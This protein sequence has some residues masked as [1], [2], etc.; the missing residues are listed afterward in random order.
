M[1]SPGGPSGL[2]DHNATTRPMSR[3]GLTDQ[4]AKAAPPV[5]RHEMTSGAVVFY[6]DQCARHAADPDSRERCKG[7]VCHSYWGDYDAASDRRSARIPSWSTVGKCDG[8]TSSSDYLMDWA[9]REYEAGRAWRDTRAE[10]GERGT[11]AHN[12]L[13]N[14]AEGLDVIPSNGYDRAT[15]AAW[16]ALGPEVVHVEEV[17]YC[18]LLGVA[19]RFDLMANIGGA[20]CLA[21]LKTSKHIKPSFAVQLNG[22]A[23]TARRAGFPDVE[24]LL[25]IQVREDGAWRS[26]EIPLR[27]EWAHSALDNYK[28]GR[29]IDRSIRQAIKTPW[30][31]PD[32]QPIAA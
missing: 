27:P 2:G 23:L 32:P 30:H 16:R 17:V 11:R 12:L 8:Q 15:L 6:E 22:Y 29:A 5:E 31:E 19:G 24:R 25:V 18:P 4:S 9:V 28:A 1:T 26:V 13:E 10:G 14:L 3:S 20:L 21:D 7:G